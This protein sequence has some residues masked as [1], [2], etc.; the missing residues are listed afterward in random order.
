MMNM[1]ELLEY[2]GKA[3]VLCRDR[4]IYCE[5]PLVSSSLAEAHEAAAAH[6]EYVLATGLRSDDPH[7]E[8][9]RLDRLIDLPIL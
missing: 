9:T 4:C 5:H 1:A 8:I 3:P 7:F 6:L 2:Q